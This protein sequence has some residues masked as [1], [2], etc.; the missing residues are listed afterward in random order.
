MIPP[1]EIARLVERLRA[2]SSWLRDNCECEAG[3]ACDDCR[4]ATLLTEAQLA[5]EALSPPAPAEGFVHHKQFAT[6]MA[7]ETNDF[8]VVPLEP[9]PDQWGGLARQIMMWLDCG[10]PY[11][12]RSLLDHLGRCSEQIPDWLRDEYEMK[13]LDH[14]MSKGTRCVLIYRAMIAARPQPQAAE[15]VEHELDCLRRQHE[16]RAYPCSP[17][18]SGYLRELHL[19]AKMDTHQRDAVDRMRE[20]LEPFAA[21]AE[22]YDECEQHPNGCPDN[23]NIGEAVDVTVGDLRRARAALSTL[24]EGEG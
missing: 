22:F 9:S 18:C 8:V 21:L 10:A 24:A 7:S 3:D 14:S 12:P 1:D 19:R 5:L 23:A 6:D 17:H 13:A 15:T 16:Q 2:H 11:T 4:N 20:A